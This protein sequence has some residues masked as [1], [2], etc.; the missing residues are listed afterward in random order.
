MKQVY[1]WA[2]FAIQLV[3]LQILQHFMQQQSQQVKIRCQC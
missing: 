2:F 3:R 1:R